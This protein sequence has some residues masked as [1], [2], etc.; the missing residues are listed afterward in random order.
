MNRHR[1]AD[2]QGLAAFTLV[3][4]LV[5]IGIMI[6]LSALVLP[7][8]TSINDSTNVGRAINL[9][10]NTF[11]LARAEAMSTRSYVYVG[12]I[13]YAANGIA[14]VKIAALIS[15]DGSSNTAPNN[16]RPLAKVLTVP[17]VT[18]TNYTNLPANVRAV[19]DASLQNNSD[20]VVS[21]PT[22]TYFEGQFIDAAFN[23]PCPTVVISP[24]GEVLNAANP[25]VFFRT[26]M[27]V[28]FVPTHGTIPATNDGGI[29]SY[30]GGTGQLRLTRPKA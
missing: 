21:F 10:A 23:N 14:S 3:E 30:Y 2:R 12:V 15:I 5:V 6:M 9:V 22:Q 29:V 25:S 1:Q 8:F 16:L 24:Q 27:S 7:R 11:E 26:T 18:T 28:G 17:S 19:A 13:N 20:Y 4:L